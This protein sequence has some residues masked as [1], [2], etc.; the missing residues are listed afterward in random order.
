[1]VQN[2][3]ASDHYHHQEQVSTFQDE[4]DEFLN[5]NNKATSFIINPKG[6]LI[7]DDQ[8]DC[9]QEMNM[10]SKESLVWWSNELESTRSSA[11]TNSWDDSSVLHHSSEGIFQDYELG[12]NLLLNIDYNYGNIIIIVMSL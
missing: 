4:L 12:Y 3:K 6:H 7:A 2:G 10:I 8:F 9:F 1:M 5:G 11:T